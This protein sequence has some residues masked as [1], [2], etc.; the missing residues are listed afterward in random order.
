MQTVT[1]NRDEMSELAA[2]V[3]G[4]GSLLRFVARGTSMLPFVHD[5][6]LVTVA[7]LGATSLRVGEIALYQGEVGGLI[8]HRVIGRDSIDPSIWVIRGDAF[9]GQPDRVPQQAVLGRVIAAERNGRSRRLDASHSRWAARLWHGL[10]RWRV[11]AYTLAARTKRRI[12]P[13]AGRRG[14]QERGA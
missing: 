13:S 4:R 14:D 10:W 9:S 3:L 12:W 11:L 5:G 7:P 1:L 6:D 8:A 2:E